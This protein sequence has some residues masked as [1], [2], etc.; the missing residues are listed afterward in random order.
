ME[1]GA[2]LLVMCMRTCVSSRG[3]QGWWHLQSAGWGGL[4][5]HTHSFEG[6]ISGLPWGLGKHCRRLPP[7]TAL[8]L[9]CVGGGTGPPGKAILGQGRWH[10]VGAGAG[11]G[12]VEERWGVCRVGEWWGVCRGGGVTGW[13]CVTHVS[14]PR[15][16]AVGAE[17][18]VE[19]R[20]WNEIAKGSFESCFGK[21]FRGAG[22][23]YGFLSCR[24]KHPP[25]L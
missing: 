15:E 5:A 25:E 11:A 6:D 18:W 9:W 12:G 3:S 1:E 8:P 23:S 24:L 13:Q 14:V 7:C 10:G 16:E 20:L 4:A 19:V 22:T 2:V 17:L 21:G